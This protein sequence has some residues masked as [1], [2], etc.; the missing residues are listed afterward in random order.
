M[1]HTV[2]QHQHATVLRHFVRHNLREQF[3]DSQRIRVRCLFP[4]MSC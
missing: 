2:C 4:I 3:I 1:R